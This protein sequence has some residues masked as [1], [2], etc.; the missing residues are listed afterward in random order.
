MEERPPGLVPWSV[1]RTLR[2][3]R[4]LVPYAIA[5]Q[6]LS[7][8]LLTPL[9]AATLR[10]F[11]GR[12]GR[13]SVGNFEIAAFLLTAPGMAALVAVGIVT[14]VTLYFEIAG[15]MRLLAE[16]RLAW[17]QALLVS[18]GRLHQI[19][20]LGFRQLVTVLGL[21]VPFLAA[22][23]LVYL[24]L[25]SGRDIYPLV[26]LKP[27]VFWIGAGLAGLIGAVYAALAGRL[28]L[29]WILAL[30]TLLFEPG[31]GVSRALSLSWERTRPRWRRVLAVLVALAVVE[32]AVSAAAL[33]GLTWAS[34]AI[35]ER[36]GTSLAVALPATALLLLAHGLLVSALSIVGVLATAVV[37]LALYREAVGP[38]AP[39]GVG[40]GDEPAARR[41]W[42]SWRWS[43][44]AGFVA[45]LGLVGFGSYETLNSLRLGDHLEITAHRA[46]SAHAPENTIAALR[47]AAADRADWVEIDVVRTADDRVVVMHDTDLV[48]VAQ[49]R[50]RVAQVTLAEIE[51]I[52]VG[53]AFGEAFAGERIP[54]F[55]AFLDAAKGLP[56]RLNVE[57][58]PRGAADEEPLT[59]LTVEAIRRA[60][61]AGRCRVCSQSYPAIQRARRLEPKL[62]IG[63]IVARALGDPT[64][65]DVDY[66]MVATNQATRSLVRRAALRGM[67][68]HA[69]SVKDPGLVAPLLD[70]GVANIITDDAVM[71]RAR[72]D[73]IRGLSAVDRLLLRARTALTE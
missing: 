59:R 1:S 36:L 2:A 37:V 45:L 4:S 20:L 55:E 39:L 7:V 58:K 72:F 5:F 50:R 22:I 8:L 40:K 24:G 23:G 42:P 15:M 31:V 71:V 25:W 48:R 46:G 43:L 63:F 32:L 28:L 62:Q 35:L 73:E 57:L 52:D 33:G 11:L 44:G 19:V 69:W 47:R 29:R 16:P 3:G 6:V 10:Y 14:L 54:T 70:H 34:D 17:W 53:S 26:V 41:F 51:Q 18:T 61:M 64:A 21:A 49:D 27:P 65:L 13:A 9:A 67:E 30:P 60:G 56:I 12:W 66:L 68:V 38:E